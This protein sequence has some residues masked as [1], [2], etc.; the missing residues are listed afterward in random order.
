MKSA[1][2]VADMGCMAMIFFFA[3]MI[4]GPVLDI[5]LHYLPYES[6][7]LFNKTQELHIAQQD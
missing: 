5:L 1:N 7:N 3:D 6:K 2:C 4:S